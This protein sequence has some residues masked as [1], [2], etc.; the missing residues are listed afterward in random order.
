M[1]YFLCLLILLVGCSQKVEPSGPTYAE[2]VATYNGERTELKRLVEEWKELG[3][4]HGT[5]ALDEFHERLDAAPYD[6]ERNRARPIPEQTAESNAKDQGFKDQ[7]KRLEDKIDHQK[8][9][10]RKA[11]ETKIAL[12]PT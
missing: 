9:L 6:F 5:W 11:E 8:H 1:R 4:R 3:E 10:V 2:A 7:I 12:E